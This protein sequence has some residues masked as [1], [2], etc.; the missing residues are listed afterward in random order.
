MPC[1]ASYVGGDIT[2]GVLRSELYKQEALTIF[3]DIGTN[4]EIVLGN[5]DW[6]VAASC[7]AGP[8]FEGGGVKCGMRATQGAIE[9]VRINPQTLEPRILVIGGG[10]PQ[11]ICGSGII[12]ALAQMLIGGI[13]DQ[14]GKINSDLPCERIRIR[15]G[16]PEYVLVWGR[17]SASGE[18]IVLTEVD[19]D[20]IMRAKGAIYAG[21]RTLLQ[22]V[23]LEFSQVQQFLIAG[24]LG[25][26]LN[27]ESAVTIGLLP[28]IPYERF[29][30][31]G[32]SSVIGAHLALLSTNLR[33]A[34]EGI[35]NSMTNLELSVSPAFM[36]EYLS[37]LFLPHTDLSAFPRV[38]ARLG[39]AN[40][41]STAD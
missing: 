36:Q 1:V 17:E 28:D 3:I 41:V 19:I 32:N 23:G 35:A 11:G 40:G 6:L 20:N 12:D 37:A 38:Q 33:E 24:G 15:R 16:L 7:S 18:D 4:G 26:F 39:S 31:L 8:A 29:K 13:I 22:E 9:Q 14:K 21:F 10:Q 5:Q 27:I 2:A 34:A 25:N 30:Y